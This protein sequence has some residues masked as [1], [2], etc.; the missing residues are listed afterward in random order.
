MLRGLKQTLSI[1]EPRE[2]TETDT[3]LY[4]SVFCGGGFSSR[5]PQ[6]QGLWEQQTWVW[7]SPLGGGCHLLHHRT[8]RTYTGLGNKLLEGTNR[9]LCA[10]GSRRKEQSSHK[11]LSQICLGVSRSHWQRLRSAVASCSIERLECSSTC[12][13]PFEGGCNSLYSE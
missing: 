11:R 10:P 1:S 2:P 6:G 7:H 9:T 8:A 4:L 13:G 5:L 12:M 3:D